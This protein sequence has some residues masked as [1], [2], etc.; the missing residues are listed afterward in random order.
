MFGVSSYS[1]HI[2]FIIEFISSSVLVFRT[3]IFTIC[4]F[5]SS[6]ILNFS[7]ISFSCF[8]N[9]SFLAILSC[10]NSSIFEPLFFTSSFIDS[11]FCFISSIDFSKLKLSCFISSIWLC[12][13]F[14]LCL[15]FS[16]SCNILSCSSCNEV[17]LSSNEDTDIFK[18]VIS[19]FKSSTYFWLS[20]FI[21]AN[22][23]I[24]DVNFSVSSV[25]VSISFCVSSFIL[26]EV[27][28]SCL[29]VSCSS[30]S[31]FIRF[32]T[33][34]IFSS[35]DNT[36]CFSVAYVMSISCSSFSNSVTSSKIFSIEFWYSSFSFSC[37][38]ILFFRFWISFWSFSISLPLPKIFTVFFATEPPV[39]APDGFITS[40]SIVIIL[41]VYP[42][43]LATFIAFSILSTITVLPNKLVIICSYFLL[44]F[45]RS[46][47]IPITPWLFPFILSNFLPWTE[48]IGKNDALPKL[49]FLKCSTNL[50]ASSSVSV[51]MFCK[52]IPKHISIAVW[53]CSG[54][55]I[56]FASTPFIPF[57]NSFTF[58]QSNKRF[59][60]LL[61]YPSFSFS[62]SI[63]NFKRDSFI[64]I[65]LWYAC[66]LLSYNFIFLSA[67]SFLEFISS[68]FFTILFL[69]LS[70][71]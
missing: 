35:I 39:I 60:T 22:S 49:F 44:Y 65:S 56:I 47:A 29:I 38:S 11:I 50:F 28:F 55:S 32:S 19:K 45:I 16:I 57:P 3:S 53:Y 46:D 42:F 1:S 67:S 70:I 20:L 48:D 43:C 51:T 21:F 58:S 27:S 71:S 10:F 59:F 61:T 64:L 8:A 14:I 69:L 23:W 63:K 5:K 12:L 30:F 13:F 25:N 9:F 4:A 2:L 24:I 40:P 37:F 17:S 6:I 62:V 54:T 36:F 18:F 33:F 34:S 26:I 15:E 41:N 52:L 31:L 68:K 7:F 66:I